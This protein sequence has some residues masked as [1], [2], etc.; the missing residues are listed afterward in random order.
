MCTGF[1]NK[2]HETNVKVGGN[3]CNI[4]VIICKFNVV[5]KYFVPYKISATPGSWY[6]TSAT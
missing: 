4:L 1:Y 3:S 5:W 2:G 6:Y